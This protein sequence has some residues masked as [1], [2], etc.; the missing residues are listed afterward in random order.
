MIHDFFNGV[1][2]FVLYT[3][4]ILNSKN[5]L[6]Q[7]METITKKQLKA[8]RTYEYLTDFYI[9]YGIE[10]YLHPDGKVTLDF[11]DDGITFNSR[12]DALNYLGPIFGMTISET[13][14]LKG[15]MEDGG[16]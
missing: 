9:T 1:G 2:R 7:S 10:T 5:A 12:S 13:H 4:L 16:I 3:L 11:E 6:S 8:I 14:I 15:L